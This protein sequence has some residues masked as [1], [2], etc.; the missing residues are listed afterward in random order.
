MLVMLMVEHM[1]NAIEKNFK[2]DKANRIYHFTA[3]HA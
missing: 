2:H 3:P 1:L